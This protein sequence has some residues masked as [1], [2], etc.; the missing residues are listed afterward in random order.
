MNHSIRPHLSGVPSL[1]FEKIPWRHLWWSGI[2]ITIVILSAGDL[3]RIGGGV[4]YLAADQIQTTAPARAL[5]LL[6]LAQRMAP[7]EPLILN[8]EGAIYAAL[9]QSDRA[10]AKFIQA[11]G[12]SAVSPPA[13]LSNL[14]TLT[15]DDDNALDYF[16]S[17]IA[18]DPDNAT[19]RLNFGLLLLARAAYDEAVYSLTEATRIESQWPLAHA[20][21]G[22]AQL[23]RGYYVAAQEAADRALVYDPQQ[24]IAHRTLLATLYAQQSW[25]ALLTSADR[26]LSFHTGN[27]TFHYY[28][29][30]A[31][32]HLNQP[33]KALDVLRP[34]FFHTA[35]AELRSRIAAE[36]HYLLRQPVIVI[37]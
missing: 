27:E 28:R 25:A 20:Y 29:G 23:A 22:V 12:Q 33:H 15:P 32:S 1:S 7:E 14:G 36:I 6:R 34:L 19:A 37:D 8:K 13:L 26:A 16:A 24:P 2:V 31:L 3:R 11:A 18:Q 10:Y 30:V 9:H 5:T 17:A 21:L 35:D 4:L